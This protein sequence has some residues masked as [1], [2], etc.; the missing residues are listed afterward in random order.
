MSLSTINV[1]SKN[2]QSNSQITPVNFKK[3]AYFGSESV[4]KSKTGIQ[5]IEKTLIVPYSDVLLAM[6]K[7]KTINSLTF[8]SK[9]SGLA[10]GNQPLEAR[11]EIIQ[12]NKLSM[13]SKPNNI[14]AFIPDL[15][16]S[17]EK[18]K[19]VG[20]EKEADGWHVHN[21]EWFP[22]ALDENS[23]IIN[24]GTL[25]DG[26]PDIGFCSKE[27][28]SIIYADTEKYNNGNISYVDANKLQLNQKI[29][30]T[31]CAAGEFCMLPEGTVLK[32]NEGELKVKAGEAVMVNE[33][34]N[35]VYTQS[36]EDGILKRYI[37]DPMNPASGRAFE[38]LNKFNEEKSKMSPEELS[39]A[40]AKL[41]DDFNQ[42]NRAVKLFEIYKDSATQVMPKTLGEEFKFTAKV[43]K[44]LDKEVFQ[45]INAMDFE[46]RLIQAKKVLNEI[47]ADESLTPA[48]KD[49]KIAAVQIRLLP[50]SNSHQHLKGSVPQET[51]LERA[52]Q[53]GFDD[54]KINAI[55]AAY[56][57]GEEGFANLDRFNQAYGTIGSPIRT[58]KDYQAAVKGIIEEAV[59]QGQLTTE[60]RC[61]VVGQR[62][63]L[64]NPL[65][66]DDATKNILQAIKKTCDE[67]KAKGGDAP[68]M[69]FTLL[70]YR[71]KDWKP[72][73]VLQHAQ[74]STKYAQE[75]PNLKFGFDLAGP[76]DTGYSPK[77]FK[78]AF[79]TITN[80]NK[81]VKA[82]ES[83]G[84]TVG[85]TC[86]AGE[87]PTC[88]GK[89][90][91]LAVRESLE[92][93]ADRIGHGVQAIKD[94]VTMEFLKK[95]GATVE[96][97][98]VCNVSSIPVNT[99]GLQLHPIIICRR[100]RTEK[101]IS[102]HPF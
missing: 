37:A 68:K 96:I 15:T 18:L 32:T 56:T 102:Y 7:A 40:H 8:G 70:G 62:D 23:I 79:E 25:A 28:F 61:A 90:G 95:S 69:G 41:C 81:S 77:F 11:S 94:P 2:Y 26:R 20:L 33:L 51:L 75:Y 50:K 12:K 9:N 74:L 101:N 63:E 13:I 99:K 4:L 91:Y 17:D 54:E 86:H 45:K 71:G 85:I 34:K 29:K 98:G 87:T 64:G 10:F 22:N 93:G 49:V 67:I 47:K 60:I 88:D 82:G 46:T 16:E 55:K 97:C 1:L 43:V 78:E 5:S 83:K 73:E 80:H 89:E 38:L 36:F 66:P 30:A 53:H 65:S 35:S 92:M 24:Y 6:H 21:R 58:P 42:I 3:Q 31:K 27:E 44:T 84:Q 19:S 72:E 39:S 59:K 48:Q 52:K 100:N 57:E 76:E 14:E